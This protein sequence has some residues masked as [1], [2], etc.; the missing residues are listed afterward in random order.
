MRVF[1]E[2]GPPLFITMAAY[3]GFKRKPKRTDDDTLE[4]EDLFNFLAAFPGA[5]MTEPPPQ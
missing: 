4:G 2:D 5:A 1:A 3:A